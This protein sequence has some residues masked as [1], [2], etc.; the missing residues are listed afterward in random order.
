[1]A[2]GG[3]LNYELFRDTRAPRTSAQGA[4]RELV[5]LAASGSGTVPVYG[6]IPG[7]QAVPAGT[8][9]D[10][11]ADHARLLSRPG[12]WLSAN[13]AGACRGTPAGPR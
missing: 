2:A 6:R 9:T 12:A 7:A 5:K 10:T 11:V 1:M 8:Y 13:W 4:K 3:L